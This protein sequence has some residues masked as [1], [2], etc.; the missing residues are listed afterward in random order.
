MRKII[1]K[2]TLQF[3]T[4][5]KEDFESQLDKLSK[6]IKLIDVTLEVLEQNKTY[7][8]DNYKLWKHNVK[9]GT[10]GVFAVCGNKIV[11][12]VWLKVKGAKDPYFRLGKNIGYLSGSFVDPT[13]RGKG[14]APAMMS[15]LV[16]NN[17]DRYKICGAIYPTNNPSINSL[18]KL[19]GFSCVRNYEFVRAL[20]MTWNKQKLV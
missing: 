20:K 13:Y 5:N 4:F 17:C 1:K 8:A 18:L 11:G 10:K 19:G 7:C 14:I 16:L 6:D 3:Y 2:Y 9:K 15:Y 12:Y